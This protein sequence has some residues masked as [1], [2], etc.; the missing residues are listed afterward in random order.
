MSDTAKTADR[1]VTFR[2]TPETLARMEE[3]VKNASPEL[4]KA[5]AEASI[6]VNGQ[7]RSG[8]AKAPALFL[9][10]AVWTVFNPPEVSKEKQTRARSTRFFARIEQDITEV[11]EKNLAAYAENPAAW[12]NLTAIGPT[13][14]RARNHNPKSVETWFKENRERVDAHHA[15]IGI[16]DPAN[17][18]RKAGKA[19]SLRK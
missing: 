4:Q 14:L 5:I 8:T 2:A 17:H 3:F 6:S 10:Y 13:Y 19:R 15:E 9:D 11:M 18:N 7:I 16:T 1:S 12:W